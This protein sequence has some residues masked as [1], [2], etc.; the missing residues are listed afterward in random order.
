MIINYKWNLQDSQGKFWCST[1]VQKQRFHI[2]GKGN[3]GYC[4]KWSYTDSCTFGGVMTEVQD[5]VNNELGVRG[6]MIDFNYQ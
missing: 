5:Y 4:Q 1:K 3:W 6:I 2:G